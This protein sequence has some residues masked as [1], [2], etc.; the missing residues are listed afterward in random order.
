M[1]WFVDQLILSVFCLIFFIAAMIAGA[2]LG[3]SLGGLFDD[4][5][6][7]DPMQN[8]RQVQMVMFGISVFIWSLGS[9]FYFGLSELLMRGQTIG[10]RQMNIRV[11]KADGFALDPMGVLIRTIFRLVDQIPFLWIVPVVSSRQQRFGDMAA[12]TL[13]VAEGSGPNQ[14]IA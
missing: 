3:L 13:V 12:R 7:K 14:P 9:F 8:A 6:P 4:L 5:D 1:A 2:A 11:V 10:K